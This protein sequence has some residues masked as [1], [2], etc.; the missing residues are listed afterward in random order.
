MLRRTLTALL[1]LAAAIPALAQTQPFAV[2]TATKLANSEGAALQAGKFCATPSDEYARP[3]S[4]TIPGQG[5]F[6]TRKVCANVSAGA[7]TSAVDT[8]GTFQ[9]AN[10][11]QVLNGLCYNITVTDN[12]DGSTTL[13]GGTATHDSG[14]NCVQM[15]S[16]WCSVVNSVYTCNFDL[17][18]PNTPIVGV[19]SVPSQLVTPASQTTINGVLAGDGAHVGAANS[20]QV[21]NAI[22]PNVYDAAGSAAAALSVAQTAQSTANTAS[23]NASS[24]LSGSA[25]DSTARS[26]LI[27]SA[28]DSTARS[29]ISAETTRA[30]AAEST[31]ATAAA[32]AQSTANT[33]LTG[34]ANDSTARAQVQSGSGYALAAYHSGGS[35]TVGPSNCV[36]D[37]TGNNLTCPGTITANVLTNALPSGYTAL[38]LFREGSGTTSADLSSHSNTFT[39][40]SGANAPTWITSGGV[41]QGIQ[42]ATGATAVYGT[43]PASTTTTDSSVANAR[44][45]VACGYFAPWV[46]ATSYRPIIGY[47][48]QAQG[49]W[50]LN[51]EPTTTAGPGGFGSG[52]N[53]FP[54]IYTPGG[55]GQTRG[56]QPIVG[57][58]CLGATLGSSTDSTKDHLYVDGREIAFYVAQ[59]TGQSWDARVAGN[60]AAIG[61]LLW[62]SSSSLVGTMEAFAAWPGVETATQMY[63]INQ[64]LQTLAFTSRNLNPKGP[65]P[66]T[67]TANQIVTDGDSI[68]NGT[69]GSVTP[70]PSL[71]GTGT[72][73]LNSTF[74]ITN[75]G[76][77]SKLDLNVWSDG[78]LTYLPAASL[79]SQYRFASDAAGINDLNVNTVA[80]ADVVVSRLAV[81]AQMKQAAYT[82]LVPTMLSSNNQDTKVEAIN[83]SLR[84]A[85]VNNGYTVVDWANEPCLGASGAYNNPGGLGCYQA[86]SSFFQDGLHPNQTGMNEMARLYSVIVNY[87]TGATQASPTV[88]TTNT[89]TVLAADRFL[90]WTGTASGTITL[91][92]CYGYSPTTPFIVTNYNSGQSLSVTTPAATGSMPNFALNGVVGGTV[93]IA[94]NATVRFYAN[95]LSSTAS[96]CGWFSY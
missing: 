88:V 11:Q 76:A 13:G 49:A 27:G 59:N 42:L 68:T 86:G 8:I 95:I 75:V 66:N 61:Y 94:N 45:L 92:P 3:T 87:L 67:T 39:F 57:Y 44:T 81:Y 2:I 20:V 24:A 17:Y 52:V 26:A 6:T 63:Q 10:T 91:P 36:T 22:G 69:P 55:S 90:R 19:A 78:P 79:N 15:N 47:S 56:A 51:G 58:H 96:G 21:Q 31:N 1:C 38:V 37:S 93:S 43:F 40:A 71:L 9:L 64:A 83:A 12:S 80:A 23:T 5:Q 41:V 77:A 35:T 73:P 34:S 4:Y 60:A 54:A 65:L 72:A 84:I 70:Y 50:W 82:V 62:N 14:Y 7:I 74:T 46:A 32:A 25:D 33:A 28:N 29:S 30:E 89:Y 53:G 18:T 85:A 48:T 16:T